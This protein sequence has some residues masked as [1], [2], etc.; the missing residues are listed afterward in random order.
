MTVK[1][2]TAGFNLVKTKKTH[3]IQNSKKIFPRKKI[4]AGAKLF[5]AQ[6]QHFLLNYYFFGRMFN[7][8]ENHNNASLAQ[9]K[10]YDK[11]ETHF[12]FY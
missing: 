1:K 11:T 5:Q 6:I 10:S 9:F 3:I 8:G 12:N 2:T 4:K 7:G